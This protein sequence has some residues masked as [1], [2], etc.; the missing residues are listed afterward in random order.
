MPLITTFHTVLE[1]PTPAQRRVLGE[2]VETSA[3]V[4]V[5]A[6]KGG[7]LP[8]AVYE[9]STGKIEVI[10]HGT[11]DG[12][13]VDPDEA[14]CAL[15]FAG[16]PVILTFG[17]LAPRKGIEVAFQPDGDI[18]ERVTVPVADAQPNGIEAARLIEPNDARR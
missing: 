5:I 6:E 11:P 4:I 15:G 14:K 17:L 8:R 7:E 16:R 18:S 9:V 13:L 10:P 1:R 12:A 2:I 3:R